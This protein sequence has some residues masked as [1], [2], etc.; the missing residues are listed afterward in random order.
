MKSAWNALRALYVADATLVALLA[1]DENGD[2][3]IYPQLRDAV[4]DAADFPMVTTPGA[5][6]E[7]RQSVR[8]G[9]VEISTWLAVHMQD[10]D[11]EATRDAIDER[12]VELAEGTLDVAWFYDGVRVSV[13]TA[14]MR[15]ANL[16]DRLRRRRIW[17]VGVA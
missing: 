14:G 15:D 17:T 9:D 8:A 11:P 16:A 1:S 12:M 10:E 7:R 5:S 13:R 3:A 2:P 6:G 4:E